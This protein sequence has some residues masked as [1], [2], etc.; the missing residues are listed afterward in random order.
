MNR[1]LLTVRSSRQFFKIGNF[2]RRRRCLIIIL[3]LIAGTEPNPGPQ[4]HAVNMAVV[5]AWSI[6]NKTALIHDLIADHG[7]GLLAITETFVYEDS[8]D[9]HKKDVAPEGYSV[10]HQHRQKKPGTATPRGGGVALI[11]RNDIRVKML[12]AD[13]L[14]FT[15]CEIL[16][17][18]LTNV[19]KGV[20]V[21]I[22]YRPPRSQIPDFITEMT[23]LLNSGILGDRFIICGDMNCPGPV[24]TKEKLNSLFLHMI[25]EQNLKQHVQIPTCR[26][27]NILDHILTPD[28]VSLVRDVSVRDVGLSDHFLVTCKISEPIHRAPAVKVTFRRWAKMDIDVF[29]QRLLSSTVYTAPAPTANDFT[30]QLKADIVEILDDIVPIQEK[31]KRVGKLN[32]KWLSEEAVKAK[33]VRRQLER[34]WN[35][36][37]LEGVRIAYRKACKIANRLINESRKSFYVKSI[38]ESSCDPKKLWQTVKGI[39][40]T[41]CSSCGDRP[42]LCAAFASATAAKI[43]KVK[44]SV[45]SGIN[46]I[47]ATQTFTER[48]AST[49]L[50]LLTPTTEAEVSRI[51]KLLPNKTSPLDYIHTSILKSCADVLAPLITRLVNLSFT[52]GCFPD[53]F[54]LAQ[55]T[56]LLKKHG[57]DESDPLNYRPISN[58]STIGKIIERLCLVRLLPHVAATGNFSILQ[59]AYR[60]RHSTETALLKILD[61]LYRIVDSKHAAVLIGLDLSAAFDTIDH[62]VLAR[63]LENMF[64]VTGTALEWFRSYLSFRTQYVKVGTEQ[65]PVTSITVGVPQGSVL[66]PF[67]FSVYVSPI[68][69]VISSY[70]VK[71]HQYADDT[72]IY[73]AV[74]SG[75]D[76]VS[77]R[78]LELCSCAVRDWFL[79][80]GMLLNPDKSELLL[81]ARKANAQS[82][83]GGSGVTVA[84]SDITF[85]VNLKS[86]G[87]TLDQSLSFDQHVQNIVK[88]S[89]Y[90]IKAL[91]HIRPY[92]D[93][94]VANTVACSIVTARLDYCNSLLYGTSVANIKKLQ[95]VQNTLAR[96]VAGARRYDSATAVMKDLHWLPIQQRI[97][98]KVNLITHRVL[99]EQQPQYLAELAVKHKPTREL[100]SATQNQLTRPSGLTS[101]LGDKAYSI[102]A[103]NEW[104]ALPSDMKEIKETKSFKK[105]LKTYLFAKMYCV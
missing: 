11:Y 57:L 4:S 89:N 83:A 73:T 92:L 76:T 37:R 79:Q 49:F 8:P 75:S 2:G 23:N 44:T 60:K 64:G 81:I 63:R 68:A 31:T 86:L 84:G 94:A 104:N 90:H 1:N 52:E 5:N 17:V 101:K 36:T 29:K 15:S 35:S 71:Y 34:K 10:V 88:A 30:T 6:V 38:Q 3:L 58:L 32:N 13:P 40:H 41:N 54:K 77:I 69:D 26:T 9:V 25:E 39:L 24:N 80:N 48:S 14:K 87:V 55:V 56:P 66:G 59:S 21:A 42:G 61:D 82:F 99:Q 100:R 45:M 97:I 98:Y 28:D 105:K 50:D 103:F 20:T 33:Q 62:S 19:A 46:N 65:T 22:V 16:L 67:L 12:K 27:G 93:K 18:K 47:S 53:Q 70:G 102:A 7:L 43:D 72:Q 85:S 91:R 51:I 78:N 96:V 95:R 74:K